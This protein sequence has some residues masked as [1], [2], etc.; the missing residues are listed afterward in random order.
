MGS[1]LLTDTDATDAG[2]LD[3][4]TVKLCTAPTETPSEDGDSALTVGFA[5]VEP[6]V[7]K[8]IAGVN[9]VLQ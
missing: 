9:V 6:S 1:E 7:V 8:L 5:G 4:V 3:S 2:A